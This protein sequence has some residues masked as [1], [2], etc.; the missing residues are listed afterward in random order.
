MQNALVVIDYINELTHP[1]GKLAHGMEFLT[2]HNTIANANLAIQHARKHQWLLVFVKVGFSE[3]Y[4]E[5]PSTSPVFSAAPQNK[6]LQLGQW[7]TEFVDELQYLKDDV[8]VT[9][10]R[11]SPFCGTDL[12]MILR[13]QQITSIYVAGF[14][15]D[16]AVQSMVKEGHDRDF[17]MTVITDACGAYNEDNHNF[18][19]HL[20]KRVAHQNN[21][22]EL[23]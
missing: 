3:N 15:T 22:N 14:S 13:T 20:M 5:C 17:K 8:T 4:T 19:L 7:G 9:K 23:P 1:N 2:R 21:A 12:E 6:V 11:V 10:H 16:M 18:A